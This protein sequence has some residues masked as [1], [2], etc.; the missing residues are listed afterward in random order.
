MT[1][2]E[3]KPAYSSRALLGL[4]LA[5]FAVIGLGGIILAQATQIGRG[6]GYMVVRPNIFPLIVGIGFLVLGGLF[7][8]R[9]TIWL[10]KDLLAEVTAEEA[11]TDWAT[12]ALGL[13][14]CGCAAHRWDIPGNRAL[15]S[16]TPHLHSPICGISSSAGVGR[17]LI[18]T[19]FSAWAAGGPLSML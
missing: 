19:A 13:L 16:G 8:L 2:D 18:F 12:T 11:T 7:L 9:T 5:A 3:H 10:D 1:P 15:L 14:C 6:A 4:R 17:H